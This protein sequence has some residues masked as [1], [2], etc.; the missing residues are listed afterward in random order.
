MN[1]RHG[2]HAGNFADVVKHTVLLQLLDYLQQKASPYCFI[3]T[4]A[5]DGCYDLTALPTQK[6]LE[7]E[8]GIYRLLMMKPHP[9]MLEQYLAIACKE[10]NYL[11]SPL[12][13]AQCSRP[14]DRIILNE[15]H[16]ESYLALKKNV[17]GYT[18]VAVHERDAYEFLP[19]LLP[20][21]E[22]RGLVLIDPAFEDKQEM[23]HLIACLTQCMRRWPQGLYLI[24]LPIVGRNDYKVRDL[25]HIGFEKYLTIEFYIKT[26]S[27]DAPGL[28]GCSLLLI[29]PPW[30]IET[31]LHPLLDYLWQVLHK[32]QASTWSIKV[33]TDSKIK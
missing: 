15:K 4:H 29:N 2:F 32:D 20:P 8:Q 14:I 27:V 23:Q 18:N 19:A 26:P 7:A 28:I 11:G 21:K 24:W 12:L 13:A 5:G 33:H 31:Q 1:Y 6:T 22:K 9:E 16:P 3:D 30:Q 17:Q 10:Q 25:T